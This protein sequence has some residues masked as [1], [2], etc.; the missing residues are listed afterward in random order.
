MADPGKPPPYNYGAIPTDSGNQ[1][2]PPYPATGKKNSN[3]SKWLNP[4][5]TRKWKS[6]SS[7]SWSCGAIL[8]TVLIFKISFDFLFHYLL[9]KGYNFPH[10][11]VQQWLKLF[12]IFVK[13]VVFDDRFNSRWSLLPEEVVTC[14]LIRI[15]FLPGVICGSSKC[16]MFLMW[17][18]VETWL[19]L[20]FFGRRSYQWL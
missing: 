15:L 1:P 8:A 5:Q 2:P 12:P 18:S 4:R 14:F 16:E 13:Q 11:Y 6:L 20:K 17:N 19:P 3:V 10:I 9:D 7:A